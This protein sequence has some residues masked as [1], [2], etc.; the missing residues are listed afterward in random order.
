MNDDYRNS[1]LYRLN[2]GLIQHNKKYIKDLI[3]IGHDSNEK[4]NNQNSTFFEY[5]GCL[6]TNTIHWSDVNPE[7]KDKFG[8]TTIKIDYGIDS[9]YFDNLDYTKNIAV[10][11]KCYIKTPK[12]SWRDI[13]TFIALCSPLS[14]Q[15]IPLI[16]KRCLVTLPN[17]K[18][19]PVGESKLELIKYVTDEDY[20]KID[21]EINNY[22]KCPKTS[23]KKSWI[24]N[25]KH[26]DIVIKCIKCIL[27]FIKDRKQ[28][29]ILK[30]PCG[31]GKS[32]IIINIIKRWYSKN[33]N[34]KCLILVPWIDLMEQF[35][36]YLI[37]HKFDKNKIMLI[38]T[39][40]TDIDN[41]ERNYNTRNIVI[42]VYNS[43]YLLKNY[44]FDLTIV[45][46]AHHLIRPKIFDYDP[47]NDEDNTL[48]NNIEI[49]K[50]YEENDIDKETIDIKN[51]E[52][53]NEDNINI[54][55]EKENTMNFKNQFD[56]IHSGFKIFMSATIDNPDFNVSTREAINAGILNDY[57]FT[58]Y[59]YTN[60]PTKENVYELLEQHE[61]YSTVLL[62]FN[63][64]EKSREYSNF[65]KSKNIPCECMDANTSK[66]NRTKYKNDLN[67][68]KLRCI[69]SVDTISEGTNIENVNSVIYVDIRRS[70]KAIIQIN[71][72]CERKVQNKGL[73]H[74]VVMCQKDNALE[75]LKCFIKAISEEDPFIIESL[76]NHK[77]GRIGII[78]RMVIKDEYT[79]CMIESELIDTDYYLNFVNMFGLTQ[80]EKKDL[81]FEFCNENKRTPKKYE[82]YK[83]CSIGG[84]LQNQKN[85]I[86]SIDDDEYKKLSTNKYVK[87]ELD[88]Y[89]EWKQQNKGNEKKYLLFEFC[90]ENKRTPKKNEKYNGCSIG[91]WL[92]RKKN[93]INSDDEYKKL[94]TNEYVKEELDRYL[95]WKQQNKGKEKKDLLFEFCNENKRT[96]KNNEKYKGCSIGWWLS[97]QKNRIN[98]IDDEYKKLSTNEYVKEELD[99]YLEKKVF[100]WD[101]NKDLL[102][103]FCNENKRTP[104]K[105]EKYKGCS[106]SWWLSNQK[107]RISLIDGD[108][109][110]KLSTNKYVKEE[111]D[112]YLEKKKSKRRE[113][114]VFVG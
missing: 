81:L 73:S 91:G 37:F 56:T 77:H 3:Y 114:N 2:L 70:Q 51:V 58:I 18:I 66:N 112:R 14:N 83:G 41:V 68:G 45:D 49:D 11:D 42:C 113:K 111:L 86:N 16:N 32:H 94:S 23:I 19:D 57:D 13:S 47:N 20:Q 97:T 53:N 79:N 93:R 87:E 107:N 106:I 80:D 74:V 52:K 7:I 67:S 44:N 63:R 75:V 40:R 105:N 48:E 92:C 101:E 85:R 12:I 95:E 78:D 36:D 104:K 29:F 60:V 28:S 89:L 8:L 25:K 62:Y 17:V 4:T 34:I 46:E 5:I 31:F 21:I 43:M 33:S 103:E 9:L 6:I 102:F 61:E 76:K 84:W 88:R 110:K 38:G 59:K 15:S 10:Q 82:P 96:P 71:G 26:H 72:R 39:G 27:Q 64:V 100:T 98:S 22:V 69:C 65:L 54:D 50:D 109:Y 108:K 55:I 24:K 35:N 30:L 99:R 1:I 90:N